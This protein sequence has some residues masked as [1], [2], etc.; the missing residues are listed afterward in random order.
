[1]QNKFEKNSRQVQD[2]SV[3]IGAFDLSNSFESGSIPISPTKIVIDPDWNPSATAFDGDVAML[4]IDTEVIS[5]SKFIKPVRLVESS[6]E[7]TNIKEGIVVGWGKQNLGSINTK[8]PRQ[9]KVPIF[10]NERCFLKEPFFA[11]ISSERT[12]CAGYIGKSAGVCLGDSGGGL[13]VS[14]QGKYF[15]VGMV[16]AAR[17]IDN[18]CDVSS[19]ALY[20]NI[21][22]LTKWI[23]SLSPAQQQQF[24]STQQQPNSNQ[25][26]SQSSQNI[27]RQQSSVENSKVDYSSCGVMEQEVEITPGASVSSKQKWPW[28]VVFYR[29]VS[30]GQPITGTGTI[31]TSRH[32]IATVC[33]CI[34]ERSIT[35]ING[36]DPRTLSVFVGITALQEIANNQIRYGV[37][38]V[39]INPSFQ[40]CAVLKGNLAMVVLDRTLQLSQNV[41][42]I[43]LHQPQ[44]ASQAQ[45]ILSNSFIVGYE[46]IVAGQ[47]PNFGSIKKHLQQPMPIGL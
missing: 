11:K 24:V 6:F 30:N 35:G 45:D 22:K 23:D 39:V 40:G 46:S 14:H 42:P 4:I 21:N 34:T 13:F 16:S 2:I 44:H 26:N 7:I 43:C 3:R 32:I 19:Y 29:L 37:S 18:N 25:F 10:N 20:T 5:Y 28:M 41:R 1:M 17:I 9:L 47:N 12:F 38:R 27:Q 8:T 36:V 15:I 33:G 31:V